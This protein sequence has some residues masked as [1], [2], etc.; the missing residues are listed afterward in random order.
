MVGK[1]KIFSGSDAGL[2][3]A[4]FNIEDRTISLNPKAYYSKSGSDVY[5]LRLIQS[6]FHEQ[7]HAFSTQGEIRETDNS[8]YT[9]IA[10][11]YLSDRP[12]N[13][14]ESTYDVFMRSIGFDGI[15]YHKGKPIMFFLNALNEGLTDSIAEEVFYEYINAK[16]LNSKKVKTKRGE[17]KYSYQKVYLLGR[18]TLQYLEETIAKECGVPVNIVK[19]GFE[20]AYF[21]GLRFDTVEMATLMNESISPDF[22]E[23]FVKLGGDNA[24]NSFSP[25]AL[26]EFIIKGWGKSLKEKWVSLLDPKT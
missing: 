3:P 23:Y 4:Y 5:E 13:L 24:F 6:L 21:S 22:Y 14:S 16:G 17:A 7:A 1:D 9:G 18:K 25:S 11:Q 26:N 10:K 8:V 15:S 20:Q 2:S 12:V 19:K